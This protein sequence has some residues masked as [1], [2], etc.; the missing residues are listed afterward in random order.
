MAEIKWN[1]LKNERLKRVRGVSFEEI[2][3]ARYIDTKN[4]GKFSHQKLMLFW[5][6][7]YI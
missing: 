3:K 7:D 2:L 6:K 1:P 4:H 5:H